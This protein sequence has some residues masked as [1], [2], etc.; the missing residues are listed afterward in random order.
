MYLPNTNLVE[1][2]QKMNFMLKPGIK[3]KTSV[4]SYSI[5]TSSTIAGTDCPEF[6]GLD[7]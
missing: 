7:L 1:I 4:S 6:K 2:L 3:V 5:L